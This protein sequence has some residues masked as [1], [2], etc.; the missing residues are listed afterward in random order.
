MPKP[1]E[2]QSSAG[3]SIPTL[4]CSIRLCPSLNIAVPHLRLPCQLLQSDRV[5]SDRDTDQISSDR[6]GY[7]SSAI[8]PSLAHP[9]A[10]CEGSGLLSLWAALVTTP[11]AAFPVLQWIDP[12]VV[13][14]CVL[15]DACVGVH[16]EW[17]VEFTF[18][19]VPMQDWIWLPCP[20]LIGRPGL[21]F[22]ALYP[23]PFCGC[24]PLYLQR[25]AGM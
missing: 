19:C 20:S 10:P 15:R 22:P 2:G 17:L 11:S 16:L 1:R 14:G 9:C 18:E 8:C 21:L 3:N 4:P 5:G 13:F 6:H 25:P 12:S 23:F 7:S 24:P